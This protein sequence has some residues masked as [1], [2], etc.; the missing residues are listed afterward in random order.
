MTRSF[1]SPAVLGK[2]VIFSAFPSENVIGIFLQAS[3]NKMVGQISDPSLNQPI[4]I[5]ADVSGNVYVANQNLATVPVFSPPYINGPTRVLQA[6]GYIPNGVA[7]SSKGIVAVGNFC[8]QLK[9]NEF[10]VVSFY[11]KGA[12]KPCKIIP[13]APNAIAANI[14]FDHAGDAFVAGQIFNTELPYV[15]EIKGGCE[16]KT[17]ESLTVGNN[18]GQVFDVHVNKQDEVALLDTNAGNI[19]TYNLPVNGSHG[20]L[21][22]PVYTT[23]APN[24]FNFAFVAS[25]LDLYAMIFG[26]LSSIAEL[27]YPGGGIRESFNIQD[28]SYVAVWPPVVPCPSYPRFVYGA[29]RNCSER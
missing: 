19:Y 25:G 13:L 23:A 17:A 21:G 28:Y 10:Y 29:L 15:A 11:A 26:N 12:T 24:A 22:K 6:P 7:V 16:A 4:V 14:S 18:V 20:S 3:P 1:L 5:A 9:C 27:T 8:N 2:P